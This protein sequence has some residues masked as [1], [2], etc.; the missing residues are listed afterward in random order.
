M[1][2]ELKFRQRSAENVQLREVNWQ[3]DSEN[4]IMGS[5]IMSTFYQALTV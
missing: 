5:F 2:T 4:S 1:V 3:E